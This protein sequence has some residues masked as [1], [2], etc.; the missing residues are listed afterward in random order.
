MEEMRSNSDPL[1]TQL[2]RILTFN[3]ADHTARASARG[4]ARDASNDDAEENA[5]R[6]LA[7]KAVKAW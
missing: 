3:A 6:L 1:R 2:T 4:V 7:M 5:F